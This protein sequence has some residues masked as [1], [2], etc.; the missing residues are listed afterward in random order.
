MLFFFVLTQ[1]L[2]L[3]ECMGLKKHQEAFME[4][5]VNGEILME[6]DE[7]VL[8]E[9]LKVSLH[10]QKVSKVYQYRSVVALRILPLKPW[11]KQTFSVTNLLYK[12]NNFLIIQHQVIK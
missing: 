11:L 3:L 8:Q 4:E 2:T 1:I 5:R 12:S 9:E 10:G 7:S 6:C